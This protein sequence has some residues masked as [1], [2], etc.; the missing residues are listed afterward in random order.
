M[1]G[2]TA[3]VNSLNGNGTITDLVGGNSTLI[4]GANNGGD[5]FTG[6]VQDGTG[7]VNVTKVGTGS[8][9]LSGLNSATG[10]LAVNGGMLAVDGAW[11]G[12]ATVAAGA[13][14]GGSGSVDGSVNADGTIAPG[15]NP[16]VLSTGD[17]TFADGSAFNVEINGIIPGAGLGGYDQLNVT[18]SV[19]IGN[20]VSL[21]TILG[22]AFEPFDGDEFVIINN[23]GLDSVVGTFAGLA[24]GTTFDVDGQTLTITYVGGDGGNDVVLLGQGTPSTLITL[25]AS[26]NLL[27]RDVNGG[28][29]NDTL[30]IISEQRCVA[31]RRK[32]A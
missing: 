10:V 32:L 22:P 21:T 28:A 24:E 6:S 25:D 18:G 1:E 5:N 7:T 8:Q 11:G 14:L 26:N 13:T 9:T 27:V 29:S 20:L 12:T 2:R 16:G 15:N 31:K 19:S 3:S 30:T 17:V 4:V 23:D